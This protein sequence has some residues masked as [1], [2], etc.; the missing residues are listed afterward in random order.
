MINGVEYGW[1]DITA[2]IAGI[3]NLGIS[4]IEYD[5]DQE[6]KNIYRAGRYP[7][8][9]GKGRITCGAKI[10]LSMAEVLAIQAKAP[11]GRIQD[12]APF[13]V[14]V[15][16]IPDGGK[17]VHDIIRDCQFKK[18]SRKW[19]EGDTSQDVELEL[20]VSAIDWHK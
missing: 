8:A 12:I 10:K 18:N 1:A 11:N 9:R 16:Y 14:Q 3:P 17:I 13:T 5:D 2:I 6:V 7:T 20:I 4:E 15:S 19:K